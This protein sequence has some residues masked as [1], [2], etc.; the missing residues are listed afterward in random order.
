MSGSPRSAPDS[1][2]TSPMAAPPSSSI[3][4]SAPWDSRPMAPLSPVG[5]ARRAARKPA[6]SASGPYQ[7]SAASQSHASEG[8][9]EF[10]AGR[11]TAPPHLPHA[12]P[13]DP[14]L[15][16]DGGL[17]NNPPHLLPHPPDYTVTSR[18]GRPTRHSSTSYRAPSRTNWDIWRIH[19][20]GENSR[21]H[22]VPQQSRN[23]SEPP[24]PADTDVPRHRSRWF[25]S[26]ALQHGRRTPHTPPAELRHRP[27]HVASAASADG[28]RLVVTLASPRTTLWRLPISDSPVT[29]ATAR[30]NLTHHHYWILPTSR[31]G[32]SLVCLCN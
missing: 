12:R 15:V 1:S 4:R 30:S 24:G 20:T 17:S 2:T 5:F 14:L 32:L 26:M 11:T 10:E 9:A 21:T 18:C 29:E 13:G 23:S 27:V 22:H 25:R 8:S 19:P 3:H 16:T 28:N 6:T 7:R 31:S